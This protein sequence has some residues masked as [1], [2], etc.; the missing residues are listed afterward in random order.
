MTQNGN[1]LFGQC[2]DEWLEFKKNLVKES[3]YFNYK[4]TVEKTLNQ[5]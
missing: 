2:C 3:S 5:F 1:I 4:F